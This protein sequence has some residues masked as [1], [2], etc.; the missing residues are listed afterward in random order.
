M[1]RQLCAS[2]SEV[3][4]TRTSWAGAPHAWFGDML[5]AQLHLAGRCRARAV[6]SSR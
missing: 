5:L 3:A 2:K 4:A 6:A 1:S